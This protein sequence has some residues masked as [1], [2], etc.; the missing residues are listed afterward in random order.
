MVTRP[1]PIPARPGIDLGLLYDGN[2]I[3]GVV[4]GLD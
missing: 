1:E 3:S 2:L 4:S